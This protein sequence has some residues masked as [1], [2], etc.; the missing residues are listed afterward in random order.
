MGLPR[1]RG[2]DNPETLTGTDN[3]E[4]IR[5]EGGDDTLLGLGGN[6]RL[7]GDKG[8]DTLDGG[9]GN[10]RLRG[11]HGDDTLTGGTGFDR[12]KFDFQGGHDTVTD[13]TDGQD[14]LDFSNFGFDSVATLLSK[15]AQVG[16]DVVFTLDGG[17][18]ITLQNVSM[19]TLGVDDFRI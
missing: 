6:D 1:I 12:F 9:D 13:F 16:D 10:D 8:N 18:I 2:N 5:A 14:M 17:E 7:R 4:E 3:A 11:D 19:A 15:A